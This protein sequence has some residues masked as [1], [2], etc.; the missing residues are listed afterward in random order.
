[1][2]TFEP[3]S[4]H[5]ATL[6]VKSNST[7]VMDFDVVLWLGRAPTEQAAVAQA[8][9]TVSPDETKAVALTLVAP[10]IQDLFSVYVDIYHE[11]SL[12]VSYVA[13]EPV[14]VYATPSIQIIDIT[15][16]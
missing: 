13:T 12:V 3:G 1:M 7:V 4:S 6:T 15:W 10:V 16:S 11:G 2:N 9:V 14:T 5:T 8:S